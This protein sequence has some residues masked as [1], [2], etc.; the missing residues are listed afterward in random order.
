MGVPKNKHS[1][2]RTAARKANWKLEQ[3]TLTECPQCHTLKA[4]HIVC[5]EC[6]YYDRREVVKQEVK[7]S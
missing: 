6:G 5:K 1:K 3:P 7:K 2:A 4:P